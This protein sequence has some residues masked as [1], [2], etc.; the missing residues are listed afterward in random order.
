MKSQTN[1]LESWQLVLINEN[2]PFVPFWIVSFQNY[3]ENLET[4]KNLIPHES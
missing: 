2:I 4:N 1:K 3:F